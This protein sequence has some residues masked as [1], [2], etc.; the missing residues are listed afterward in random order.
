MSEI[1]LHG[2]HI[3]TPQWFR[4]RLRTLRTFSFPLSVLPVFVA[5]A[6]IDVVPKSDAPDRLVPVIQESLGEA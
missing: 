3:T 4:L 5:A 1:G 2:A 6:A